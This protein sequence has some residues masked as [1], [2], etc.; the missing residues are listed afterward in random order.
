MSR[1]VREIRPFQTVELAGVLEDTVLRF[2]K[3]ECA[4]GGYIEVADPEEYRVRRAEVVWAPEDQF[5]SFTQTLLKGT[6][7]MDMDPQALALVIAVSTAYLKSTEIVYRRAV[8]ELDYLPRRVL[9]TD[10]RPDALRAGFHGATVVT[11]LMLT[12]SVPRV[13]LKPWRIGTWLARATYRLITPQAGGL[14]RPAALN[15]ER[16]AELVLPSRTVRYV[17]L[18]DHD[19][20]KPVTASGLPTLWVDEDLLTELNARPTS[21]LSQTVQI[22]LFQDFV[23]TVLSSPEVQQD[24]LNGMEWSDLEK[25]LVGRI[26]RLVGG[27]R[28]DDD[29]SRHWI[30]LLRADPAKLMAH[31]EHAV[32]LRDIVMD[33][34]REDQG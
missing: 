2:G 6:S 10:P 29:K 33:A 25:T 3:D 18:G 4:A 13:P 12:R 24:D 8:S 1:E 19:L 32:G 7:G 20:L 30:Q 34:F 11:Y 27:S 26:I 16:R 5:A 9:I 22:Q 23:W 21:Q 31:V 17:E 14:F 15:A 28:I